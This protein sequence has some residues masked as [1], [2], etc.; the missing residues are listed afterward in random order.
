ME[1]LRAF[2]HDVLEWPEWTRL[3]GTVCTIAH[4]VKH[5]VLTGAADPRRAAYAVG[6]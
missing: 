1:G 4:D 2:G 3:A 5:G 6:W